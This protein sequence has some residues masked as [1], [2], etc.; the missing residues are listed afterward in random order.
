[1][2]E[3]EHLKVYLEEC[4]LLER[5][6]KK[7]IEWDQESCSLLQDTENLWH[8]NIV[9]EDAASSLI[10]R[11]EHHILSIEA[12][13]TAGV[14]LGL[15]L[16]TV[17]K[18]RDVCSMLKWCICVLSYSSRVPTH[19]VIYFFLNSFQEPIQHLDSGS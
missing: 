6:L 7:S 5:V 8:V 18:L 15:E 17:P 10:P 13:V 19:K 12:A 1:M 4:S 16:N 9:G 2:L 3:S 11:L 14:S